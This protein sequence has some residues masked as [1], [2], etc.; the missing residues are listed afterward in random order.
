MG[1]SMAYRFICTG[2]AFFLSMAFSSGCSPTCTAIDS[3]ATV[4]VLTSAEQSAIEANGYFNL[5]G[6]CDT[7][8]VACEE[9]LPDTCDVACT[10][11]FTC[12]QVSL[13]IEPCGGN[14]FFPDVDYGDHWIRKCLEVE[15]NSDSE[16]TF[17]V[18]D[19]GDFFLE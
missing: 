6:D 4:D 14:A 5:V 16:L 18:E 1:F 17:S 10:S 13:T 19:T 3:V 2:F 7:E 11:G 9:A 12:R 15:N 8:T